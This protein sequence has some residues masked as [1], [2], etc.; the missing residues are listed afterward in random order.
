MT[1]VFTTSRS[2]FADRSVYLKYPLHIPQ[3]FLNFFHFFIFLNL[4]N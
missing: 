3:V 4:R 1:E 2:F